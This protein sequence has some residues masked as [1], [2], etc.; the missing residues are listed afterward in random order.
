MT[1]NR[2]ELLEDINTGQS[3]LSNY[4]VSHYDKFATLSPAG[5]ALSVITKTVSGI[6][7]SNGALIGVYRHE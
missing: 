3:I 7:S 5:K 2:A 4:L 1:Y 6:T